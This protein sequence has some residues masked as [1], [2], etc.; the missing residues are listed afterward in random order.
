M[1]ASIKIGTRVYLRYAV[2]GDPGCIV[3]FDRRGRAIVEWYDLDLGHSTTHD[4]DA[5]V[6]DTAF[7]VRQLDLF[8]EMAA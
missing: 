7:T 2:A 3:G 1:S 6:V 8:E 5:L 4:L